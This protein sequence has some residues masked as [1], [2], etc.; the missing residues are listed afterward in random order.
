MNKIMYILGFTNETHFINNNNINL[1][2]LS[3]SKIQI[4]IYYSTIYSMEN[5]CLVA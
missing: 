3:H 4:N 1:L 5:I 2:L